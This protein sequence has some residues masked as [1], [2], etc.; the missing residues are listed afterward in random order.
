MISNAP[1]AG[2]TTNLGMWMAGNEILYALT[3]SGTQPNFQYGVG[4]LQGGCSITWTTQKAVYTSTFTASYETSV[5]LASN[6][7][8][9]VA[10]RV[11][12]SSYCT[13]FCEYV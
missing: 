4:K 10:V 2:A 5:I 13:D 7:T 11:Y 6:H 12:Q 3:S 8:L 1:G 9:Y